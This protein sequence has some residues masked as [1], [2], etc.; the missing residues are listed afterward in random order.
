MQNPPSVK[1]STLGARAGLVGAM[2]YALSEKRGH[3]L[4][5]GSLMT[6]SGA[7]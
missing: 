5:H 1:I 3:V 7:K 2:S 4:T 6:A